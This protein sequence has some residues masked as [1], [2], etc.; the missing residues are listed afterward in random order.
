STVAIITSSSICFPLVPI[1]GLDTELGKVWIIMAIGVGSMTISHVND[2]YFWVVSQMSK[3]DT[4]TALRSHTLGT[5]IQGLV[6][7]IIL[8]VCYTVWI[9]I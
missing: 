4:K 2:S 6:G 9:N 5:L 3:M 7:F 1:I 8:F